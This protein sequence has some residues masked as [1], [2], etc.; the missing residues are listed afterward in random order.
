MRRAR[1]AGVTNVFIAPR[2]WFVYEVEPALLFSEKRPRGGAFRYFLTAD[3]VM[4]QENAFT[5]TVR[6][7][8]KDNIPLH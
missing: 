4:A 2:E 3:E 7:R 6:K 1:R 5:H 8:P